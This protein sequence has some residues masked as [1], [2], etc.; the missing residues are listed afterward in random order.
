MALFAK[1]LI[2]QQ[3]FI[4]ELQSQIL[5]INGAIYDGD[6]FNKSGNK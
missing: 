6:R 5:K 4:E 2:A 3:A 1:L